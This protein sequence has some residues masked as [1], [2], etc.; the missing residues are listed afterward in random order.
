M[1]VK[2]GFINVLKATSSLLLILHGQFS[3]LQ[4]GCASCVGGELC[5][6]YGRGTG[7]FL[8]FQ[9]GLRACY[10]IIY[11]FSCTS[12]VT[13]GVRKKWGLNIVRFK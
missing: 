6:I 12:T 1:G 5:K 2:L 11:V 3:R 8:T 10:R 9:G 13:C 4:G 7:C